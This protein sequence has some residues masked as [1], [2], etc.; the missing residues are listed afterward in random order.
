VRNAGARFPIDLFTVLLR[1]VT[2]HV[3]YH[4]CLSIFFTIYHTNDCMVTSD[5][6]LHLSHLVLDLIASI[7]RAQPSLPVREIIGI[8]P[9]HHRDS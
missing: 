1:E 5:A 8:S 2:P 9:L 7:I 3:R 4:D 6:D